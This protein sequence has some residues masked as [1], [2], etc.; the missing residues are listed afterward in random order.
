MKALLEAKKSDGTFAF[1]LLPILLVETLN[2]ETGLKFKKMSEANGINFNFFAQTSLS[3]IFL[4]PTLVIFLIFLIKAM[5]QLYSNRFVQ[6]ESD[7]DERIELSK[8]KLRQRV[9][10]ERA[11]ADSSVGGG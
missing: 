2:Q 8:V 6:F 9:E 3:Q 4:V 7:C 1:D 10:T 5:A 11:S